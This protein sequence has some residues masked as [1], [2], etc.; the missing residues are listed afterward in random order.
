MT[1]LILRM[2]YLQPVQPNRI[3]AWPGLSPKTPRCVSVADRSS[4]PRHRC[5]L[6]VKRSLRQRTSSPL[7]KLKQ[8]PNLKNAMPAK[9]PNSCANWEWKKARVRP[10]ISVRV[11]VNLKKTRSG[12]QSEPFKIPLIEPSSTSWESIGTFSCVNWERIKS[13]SMMTA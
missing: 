5:V 3:S 7:R 4:P 13:R 10:H 2:R 8:N 6:S 9:R 1:V 11:S 12:A